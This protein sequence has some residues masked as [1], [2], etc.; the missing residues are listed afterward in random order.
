[1][2]L[3]NQVPQRP[4]GSRLHFKI[5]LMRDKSSHHRLDRATSGCGDTRPR[6]VETKSQRGQHLTSLN[7]Y[8]RDSR[9]RQQRRHR[10][11]NCACREHA[12]GAVQ[13]PRDIAQQ[14]EASRLQQGIFSV[15]R[16]RSQH[17]IKR[18]SSDHGEA[19]CIVGATR[20]GQQRLTAR[21]L[22]GR[23]GCM[24]AHQL[25]R[26]SKV[27]ALARLHQAAAGVRGGRHV[28]LLKLAALRHTAAGDA[29]RG[30]GQR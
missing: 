21:Q 27:R 7:L 2:D 23:R 13:W 15:H 8:N 16:E 19:W 14:G 26:A 17:S 25:H 22:H 4:T 29:K 5:S 6:I 28:R 24:L 9:V 3:M 20:D 1:M 18:A 30:L 12:R 10:R 11:L